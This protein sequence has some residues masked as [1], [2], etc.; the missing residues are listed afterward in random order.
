MERGREE[1][2]LENARS[3]V[4]E[5]LTVRFDRVPSELVDSIEQI[6]DV[7]TLKQLLQQAIYIESLTAFEQLLEETRQSD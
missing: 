6:T 1:G 4:L 5:M 7:A 3:S 2:I